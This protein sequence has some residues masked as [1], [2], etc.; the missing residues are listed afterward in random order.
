MR[1]QW[2]KGISN[3]ITAK[4]ISEYFNGACFLVCVEGQLKES[5]INNIKLA[6]KCFEYFNVN[7]F[8]ENSTPIKKDKQLEEWFVKK[9]APELEKCA[10]IEVLVNNT[11]LGVG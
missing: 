11:D 6:F 8:M 3:N 1:T 7:V 5:I 10:N 2:N 4:D 9:V